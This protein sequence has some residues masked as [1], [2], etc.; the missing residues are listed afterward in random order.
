MTDKRMRKYRDNKYLY[1]HV[2]H[3]EKLAWINAAVQR[4][5]EKLGEWL[6]TFVSFPL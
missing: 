6:E 2:S 3:A 1:K 5:K 4:Q